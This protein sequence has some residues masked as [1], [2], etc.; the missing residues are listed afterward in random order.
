VKQVYVQLI[1]WHKVD[2]NECQRKH[3]IGLRNARRKDDT[4]SIAA[5]SR[6]EVVISIGKSSTNAK[7]QTND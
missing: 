1:H 5:D 7:G 4:R 3:R 6:W 2:E